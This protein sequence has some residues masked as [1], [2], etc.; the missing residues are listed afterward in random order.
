LPPEAAGYGT[1]LAGSRRQTDE[2]LK[3]PGDRASGRATTTNME[4]SGFPR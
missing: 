2:A 3:I 4:I 1:E